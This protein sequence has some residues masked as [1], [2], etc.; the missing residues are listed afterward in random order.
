MWRGKLVSCASTHISFRFWVA[1]ILII[2]W[3]SHAIEQKSF[4][5]GKKKSAVASLD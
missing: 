5:K 4:L 3:M 1:V 2:N